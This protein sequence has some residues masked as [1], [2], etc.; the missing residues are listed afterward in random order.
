MPGIAGIIRRGAY[1]Q[2]RQELQVMTEAMRH[3]EFYTGG[4]YV[5]EHCGLYL[6]WLAH[7]GSLG[8]CMPLVSR[9]KQLLIILVGEHFPG[10]EVKRSSSGI[11]LSDECKQEL[12]SLYEESEDEFL[13][14]L[15]GWFSGVVV[16]RIAGRV[17]LFNDRYGMGRIYWHQGDDEFLFGTEAKS[18]LKVR[19]QLRAIEPRALAQYLSFNCVMRNESLFKDI[20]LMPGGSAWTFSAG[21]PLT[22]RKYFEFSDWEQQPTLERDGFFEK[23]RDTVSDILPRYSEEGEEAALSL[24]AGLDTRVILA[25]ANDINRKFPCYTFGGLWGETYDIRTAR[26]LA[27][28]SGNNHEVIRIN[29]PFLREFPSYAQKACVHLGWYT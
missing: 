15:N 3:Q 23:F 24:T 20:A 18:L 8:A 25:G 19:P 14:S 9:D 11:Q 17:T 13:R 21:R 2:V 6:G 22:R 12:F 10:F 7:P 16:D 1:P 29:E 5:D 4:Q 27:K 28:I 26:K